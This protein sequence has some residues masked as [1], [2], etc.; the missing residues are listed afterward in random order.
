MSSGTAIA[1]PDIFAYIDFRAYLTDVF[2]YTKTVLPVLS[3]RYISQKVGSGSPGWFPNIM[4][5]RIN[6]TGT[7][8]VRLAKLFELKGR[9]LDYFELLVKYGQASSIDEKSHYLEKIHEFKGVDARLLSKE[10]YEYYRHWYFGAIRELL[11]IGEHA[12]NPKKIASQLLPPITEAEARAAIEVLL[13][14]GLIRKTAGGKFKAT[15]EVIRKDPNFKSVFW[16]TN[17]QSKLN[18]A[19]QALE[20]F[21]KEQRDFSEVVIPLSAESMETAREEIAM[22]RKK[23]LALSDADAS[24]DQV[25]QCS[26]QLFPLTQKV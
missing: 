23:L 25:F 17:M 9:Q 24:R 8:L 26:I 10:Q 15:D 1:R 22:L 12:D 19:L 20:T 2:A 4:A 3:H 18:L 21:P 5:G 14:L 16:A 11:L 7:Y 6:L 13:K